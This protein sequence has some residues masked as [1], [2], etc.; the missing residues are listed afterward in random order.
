MSDLS[1]FDAF[2]ERFNIQPDEMGAAFAAWLS[3]EGWDGEY[4]EVEHE[5]HPDQ[6]MAHMLGAC[7]HSPTS[8]RWA[9]GPKREFKR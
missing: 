6:L 2:V 4:E 1:D 3:G 9:C 7:W 5:S 8:D